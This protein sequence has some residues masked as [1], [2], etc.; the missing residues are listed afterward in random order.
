[1]YGFAY[2]FRI[3]GG[4]PVRVEDKALVDAALR[5]QSAQ[6]QGDRPYDPLNGL[7]L[8]RYVFAMVDSLTLADVRRDVTLALTRNEPRIELV[9]VKSYYTEQDAQ[10]TA[11]VVEIIWRYKGEDTVNLSSRTLR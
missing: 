11:L 10:D 3:E 5:I 4:Q 7:D 2:P 9:G 8:E 1:M 6:S